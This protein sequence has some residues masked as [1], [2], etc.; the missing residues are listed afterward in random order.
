[1]KF[2]S[3]IVRLYEKRMELCTEVGLT[4]IA[5][6]KKV[7][8][9]EREMQKLATLSQ[10]ASNEFNQR[11]ITELY[12]Q[13]MAMSRKLQYQILTEH[14]V[15]GKTAF[16]GIDSLDKKGCQTCIPGCGRGIQSGGAPQLFRGR[17]VTAF[18]CRRSVTRWKPLEDGL[19]D[20][21]VLPIENFICRGCESGI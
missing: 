6:G 2:D 12:E 15:I 8:D 3:Q 13:L 9:K 19:A 7:Y 21:A 16:I 14:G 1:M 5:S 20:Y 10:M 4:K 11:G 18:M 17:S